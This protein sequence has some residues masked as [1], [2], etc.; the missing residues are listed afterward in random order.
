MNSRR[1]DPQRPLSWNGTNPDAGATDS[2]ADLAVPRRAPADLVRVVAAIVAVGWVGLLVHGGVEHVGRFSARPLAAA[3]ACGI[4]LLVSASKPM[5]RT[6][7]DVGALVAVWIAA[8][9][10]VTGGVG[11]PSTIPLAAWLAI[12]AAALAGAGVVAG[13]RALPAVSVVAGSALVV[14]G[15]AVAGDTAARFDAGAFAE[16]P[17]AIGLALAGAV[18]VLAGALD[19]DSYAVLAVPALAVAAVVAPHAGTPA[20]VVIPTATAAVVA[21]WFDRGGLAVALTAVAALAV[22]TPA[23]LLL[24][25]AAVVV[26]AVPS[27]PALLAAVPG[28]VALAV[29]ATHDPT[30]ASV[31]ASATAGVVAVLLTLGRDL[32]PATIPLRAVPAAIA[33]VHLALAPT[34]SARWTGAPDDLGHWNRGAAIAVAAALLAVLVGIQANAVPL[35]RHAGTTDAEPPTTT[36]DPSWARSARNAALVALGVALAALVRSSLRSVP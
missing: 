22:A 34:G 24:A 36:E 8:T 21:A 2:V 32:R 30:T 9:L 1:P 20:A 18:I 28:A 14:A 5:E 19:P 26:I 10:A 25:G 11:D 7:V 33:G 15:F 6:A 27:S 16:S 31:A 35:T 13:D 29:H 23:G 12:A 17:V 3:A 4:A